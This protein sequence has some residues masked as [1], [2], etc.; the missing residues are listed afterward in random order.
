[1]IEVA[2]VLEFAAEERPYCTFSDS[3]KIRLSHETCRLS[4]KATAAG[5]YPTDANLYVKT[6]A[7]SPQAVRRW[8]NFDATMST[9]KSPTGAAVTSIG[10]KLNDGTNDRYWNGSTWAVAGAGN[11][12]T[13]AVVQANIA[14]FPVAS[15]TLRPV[16][17]LRT[18]DSRYTPTVSDV[19]VLFEANYSSGIEN[20]VTKA[21]RRRIETIEATTEIAVSWPATGAT[22]DLDGLV[23]EED[24]TIVDVD[25][26]FLHATDPDCENDLLV[27]YNTGTKVVTLSSSQTAGT[28]V[29][30]RVAYRPTAAISTHQDYDV[31]GQM[32]YVAI[33]EIKTDIRAASSQT[34][35][36]AEWNTG[37]GRALPCPAVVDCTV[38]LRSCTKS[39]KES[40][41]LA[42]A[43]STSFRN[44]PMLDLD[45]LDERV[46][47][48]LE[49]DAAIE[50]RF[51]EV[52][53]HDGPIAVRM[54]GARLWGRAS[55]Q[56][57][58]VQ[59]IEFTGTIEATAS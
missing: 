38:T 13:T 10:W 36:F 3:T 15:K 49:M 11:W 55:T 30:L 22:Y 8:T 12:N 7:I 39:S 20:L 48:V 29:L 42:Q 54:I 53:Q 6:R 26:A 1:M 33:E 4:L 35:T 23:Q 59:Q 45:A 52:N 24:V 56:A 17:N 27:S 18:T 14:S 16:V 21:L 25:G 2:R 46:G 5:L 28:V 40:A 58:S 9:P 44:T 31:L 34:I 51:D 43:I 32:P 41:R 57:Y 50:P 47:V 19:R 37:M